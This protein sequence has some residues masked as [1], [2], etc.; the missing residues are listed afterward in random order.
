MNRWRWNQ[1]SK[2]ERLRKEKLG[3]KARTWGNKW[4]LEHEG[5]TLRSDEQTISLPI[6]EKSNWN[7][8]FL[9][10]EMRIQQRL[11]RHFSS[12]GSSMINK[13]AINSYMV[14]QI[15]SEDPPFNFCM[16]IRW[17]SYK[18]HEKRIWREVAKWLAY[19]EQLLSTTVV[20]IR[21]LIFANWKGRRAVAETLADASW[22]WNHWICI[23]AEPDFLHCDIFTVSVNLWYWP[24]YQLWH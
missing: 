13:S 16:C 5:N 19:A 8:P 1:K 9:F 12:V 18:W 10:K 20:R 3:G 21:Y 4:L 24:I 15:C 7:F 2:W 6:Q 14:A 11:S 22:H 17:W 23:T